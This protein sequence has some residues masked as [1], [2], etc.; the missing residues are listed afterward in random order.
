A[1]GKLVAKVV[2]GVQIRQIEPGVLL[3]HQRA[4][5]A[6]GRSN[7]LKTVAPAGGIELLLFPGRIE[8]ARVRSDPDL[9][10]MNRFAVAGVELAVEHTPAS[11]DALQFTGMDD[12]AV[13]HA[14]LVLQVATQDVSDDLHVAVRMGSEPHGGS[15]PVLVD[16]AKAME[17]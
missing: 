2:A 9:V 15:D 14:V 10:K 12:S 3:Q 1:R 17:S 5:L 4:V 13:A 16:D 7:H 11:G 6:I 8:A